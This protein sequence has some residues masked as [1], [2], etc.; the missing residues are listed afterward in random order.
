MGSTLAIA[1]GRRQQPAGAAPA[2]A[3]TEIATTNAPA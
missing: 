1:A 3:S 2:A